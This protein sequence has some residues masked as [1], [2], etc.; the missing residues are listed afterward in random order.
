M[1][2]Y[3]GDKTAKDLLFRAYLKSDRRQTYPIMMPSR[4][5]KKKKTCT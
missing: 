5:K 4:R 1:G 3:D 2:L